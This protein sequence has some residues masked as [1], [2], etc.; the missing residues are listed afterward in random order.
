M[1]GGGDYP[2][3]CTGADGL[4]QWAADDAPIV[5]NDVVVWYTFGITH[6]PRPEDW[7][8]M[9]VHRAGFKLMPSGFFTRNPAI[10]VPPSVPAADAASR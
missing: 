3:Q 1:H 6:I 4:A 2:S 7:P 5:N 10:D 9:P 8:V